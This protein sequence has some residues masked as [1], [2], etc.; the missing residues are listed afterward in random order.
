MGEDDE[1]S[2]IQ[3][4]GR[5]V[6]YAVCSCSMIDVRWSGWYCATRRGI[7]G[8]GAGLGRVA[9][10]VLEQNP[11][12]SAIQLTSPTDDLWKGLRPS[13]L[14]YPQTAQ[15]WTIAGG[16][17]WSEYE[18]EGRC[19]TQGQTGSKY[20]YEDQHGVQIRSAVRATDGDPSHQ[21]TSSTC[22]QV[23]H[24]TLRNYA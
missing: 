22:Q 1:I 12:L 15:P 16:D 6:A 7:A 3:V 17:C 14:V 9:S 23:P 21:S 19:K 2:C 10:V 8:I 20:P 11:P 24:L 13:V 5:F 18:V 4:P